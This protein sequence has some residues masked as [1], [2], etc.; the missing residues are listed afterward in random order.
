MEEEWDNSQSKHNAFKFVGILFCVLSVFLL[1]ILE[2]NLQVRRAFIR[3]FYK[4]TSEKKHSN[5]KLVR[6]Y[7]NYDNHENTATSEKWYKNF[8]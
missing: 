3:A 5:N 8:I 6:F 7:L 1:G 2:I 4:N